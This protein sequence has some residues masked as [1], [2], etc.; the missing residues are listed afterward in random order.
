MSNVHALEPVRT[1]A[2]AAQEYRERLT[3]LLE[4]VADLL[5][6][7]K[8]EGYALSWNI[9]SDSFGKRFRCVEIAVSKVL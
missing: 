1:D 2:M 9:Q 8:S 4:K 5:S 3:P 7:A 6:E